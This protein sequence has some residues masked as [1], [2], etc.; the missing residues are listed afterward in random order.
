MNVWSWRNKNYAARV[1]SLGTMFCHVGNFPREPLP[2][3]HVTT[4]SSI[5]FESLALLLLHSLPHHSHA[6]FQN[7]TFLNMQCTETSIHH[8]LLNIFQP[9][10]K[11]N[12]L[13][14]TNFTENED[15]VTIYFLF[16][17]SYT[18]C[19]FIMKHSYKNIA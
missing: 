8:Q 15:V 1:W 9:I 14:C 6:S 16:H 17:I 3:S 7:F 19:S 18:S 5:S 2:I 11:T 13:I 12:E 4:T 10:V